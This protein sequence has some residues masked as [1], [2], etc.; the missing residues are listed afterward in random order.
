MVSCVGR[1]AVSCADAERL[2]LR[3]S[4]Y[5]IGWSIPGSLGLLSLLTGVHDGDSGVLTMYVCTITDLVSARLAI[6][7]GDIPPCVSQPH[8]R[9]LGV[10]Q[11]IPNPKA[12]SGHGE[13]QRKQETSQ[14]ECQKGEIDRF[15]IE[16]PACLLEMDRGLN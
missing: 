3:R 8:D 9:L 15:F 4:F 1:R 10:V 2:T 12:R 11:D 7:D 13:L 6:E 16:A 14:C 5:N